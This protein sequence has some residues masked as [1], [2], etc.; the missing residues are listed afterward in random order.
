VLR[1]KLYVR[2]VIMSHRVAQLYVRQRHAEEQALWDEESNEESASRGL[3]PRVDLHEASMPWLKYDINYNDDHQGAEQQNA[4][5]E[6][7]LLSW[8]DFEVNAA[9][10]EGTE[11]DMEGDEQAARATEAYQQGRTMGPLPFRDPYPP[12]TGVA[13]AAQTPEP[14]AQRPGP[15]PPRARQPSLRLDTTHVPAITQ[16]TAAVQGPITY[17]SIVI[18]Q[19][20]F[21]FEN[22]QRMS[23]LDI[24]DEQFVAKVFSHDNA[25]TEIP[26]DLV[27]RDAIRAVGYAHAEVPARHNRAMWSIRTALHWVC[28]ILPLDHY[29]AKNLAG[30]SGRAHTTYQSVEIANIVQ[31]ASEWS[32][33]AQCNYSIRHTRISKHSA[34]RLQPR[35]EQASRFH[36]TVARRDVPR[37][38]QCTQFL[39]WC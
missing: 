3:P 37:W 2:S 9:S 17:W 25:C 27:S 31:T 11:I 12:R 34:F 5:V 24:P 21:L 38:S 35:G 30:Q 28:S 16:R 19:K 36:S 22:N 1:A 14:P 6:H 39:P 7:L 18:G 29:Q 23:D 13:P 32:L 20:R 33:S 8:A 4:L 15:P 10:P 26:K